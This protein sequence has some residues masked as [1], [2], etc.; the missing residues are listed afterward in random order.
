LRPTVHDIANAAGVSLATVDRVLNKRAGVKRATVERVEAAV[1]RLGYVRDISAANL[2]KQRTYR[3]V[4]IIPEGPNSFMRG[5]ER[6]LEQL[7]QPSA[8]QRIDIRILRVP[9]FDASALASTLDNLVPDAVSGLALVAT[10]S[11]LVRDALGR[12]TDA[13]VPV[14]TLVSDMPGSRRD[15][16]VGIDNV[17]AGRTAANLLGRFVGGRSGRIALIAGSMLVR[18][19]V[20]RRMGF[21]QVIRSEFPAL[22]CLPVLEGRDDADMTRDMLT[23]C[24]A[25]E[26]GVIGVYN[27]G[28]GNRGVIDVLAGRPDYRDLAVVAHEL[29]DHARKALHEGIFDAVI[30]QDAGHEARSAIRWLK[31]RIDG[32]PLIGGQE[33]IRIEIYLRDNLP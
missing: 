14:V 5:L 10:E 24:L 15:H 16:Y 12:L 4:F 22:E 29:T 32:T 11:A 30:N 1:A 31:A 13:G 20:E 9:A 25:R 6:Q 23:G 27:M 2:A 21:D 7:R 3:L 17:A 18:D 28:A 19:H 26:S 33:R 8:L